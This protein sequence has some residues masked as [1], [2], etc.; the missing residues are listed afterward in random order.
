MKY[1]K[2]QLLVFLTILLLNPFPILAVKS[3]SVT[4]KVG[5]PVGPP[6]AQSTSAIVEAAASIVTKLQRGDNGWYNININEPGVFYWCDYLVIDSYQAAGISGWDRQSKFGYGNSSGF[7]QNTPGY[8]LDPVNTLAENLKPGDVV[9]YGGG[10]FYH[11]AIIKDI[12]LDPNGNGAIE[13]YDS[14]SIE[15]TDHI[16]VNNHIPNGISQNIGNY[17]KLSGFGHI[18]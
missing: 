14:N 12:L 4:T 6:P 10:D 3:N 5:N 8:E 1:L 9:F 13:T 11:V 16:W 7:F 18:Q 15:V 17:K 2:T